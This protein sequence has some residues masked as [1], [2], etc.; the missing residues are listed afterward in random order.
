MRTLSWTSRNAGTELE[1]PAKQKV[2]ASLDVLLS[3]PWFSRRWI[4]Q[5]VV[6]NHDV[7]I[8]CGSTSLSW[9]R[10]ITTATRLGENTGTIDPKAVEALT[11]MRNIWKRIVLHED[12]G[13]GHSLLENFH[14]FSHFGC[15]NDSDQIFALAALSSDVTMS[16]EPK[17]PKRTAYVESVGSVYWANPKPQERLFRI[18]PNYSKSP[19]QVYIE[20]AVEAARNGL[21]SWL[22]CRTWHQKSSSEVPAWVPDWRIS[23][24]E[25]PYFLKQIL[26]GYSGRE[27]WASRGL[28]MMADWPK[29]RLRDGSLRIRSFSVLRS[30]TSTPF[31]QWQNPKDSV[32]V[33]PL[34]KSKPLNFEIGTD[35][36]AWVESFTHS[37]SN[38]LKSVKQSPFND[39]D[40][41]DAVFSLFSHLL[42]YG[43]NATYWCDDN[44]SVTDKMKAHGVDTKNSILC[45]LDGGYFVICSQ[46]DAENR[47]TF[48][49]YTPVDIDM[50]RDTVIRPENSLSL[51]MRSVKITLSVIRQM[52]SCYVGKP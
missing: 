34:W 52:F 16:K 15:G 31:Q 47:V 39:F 41:H 7:I 12:S 27:E 45:G 17:Y 40:V 19:E 42:G 43:P 21:F 36:L 48:L 5:E 9:V 24:P 22:L 23:A 44:A 28:P 25:K 1:G 35:I 30:R 2:V 46:G 20:F 8:H 38:F 29:A 18:V 51:S 50:K 6:R 49:A 14:A 32:Y 3:Q 4:I 37:A 10:L 26:H 13:A 33:Q 11:Q